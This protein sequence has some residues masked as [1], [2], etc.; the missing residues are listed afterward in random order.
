MFVY[1]L[2]KGKKRKWKKSQL[3][4]MS[5]KQKAIWKRKF[6]HLLDFFQRYWDKFVLEI[7]EMKAVAHITE[8]KDR[9]EAIKQ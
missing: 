2:V 3:G 5:Y 4:D 7:W 6:N 8:G 9:S 1:F